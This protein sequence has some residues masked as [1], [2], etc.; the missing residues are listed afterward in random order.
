MSKA[1]NIISTYLKRRER[2]AAYLDVLPRQVFDINDGCSCVMAHGMA[3][4]QT[5]NIGELEEHLGL[6]WGSPN[7]QRWD[8]LVL[9]CT[10]ATTPKQ[11]ARYI[12]T[13]LMGEV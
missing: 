3:L 4:A 11:A 13:H 2:L 8:D 1:I 9:G 10:T 7:M 6:E 12:R 5:L